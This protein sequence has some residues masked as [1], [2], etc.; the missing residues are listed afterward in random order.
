MAFHGVQ[1]GREASRST[2]RK[3]VKHDT[4]IKQAN[5]GMHNGQLKNTGWAGSEGRHGAEGSVGQSEN[6]SGGGR[7]QPSALAR[8][9]AQRCEPVADTDLAG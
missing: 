8:I 1:S 9:V 4:T 2:N 3:G 6:D 5:F 7:N